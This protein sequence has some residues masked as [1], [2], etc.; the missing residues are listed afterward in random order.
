[1]LEKTIQEF[2]ENM[3]TLTNGAILNDAFVKIT[4]SAGNAVLISE[5]EWNMLT[6]AMKML[7]QGGQK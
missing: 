6:D 7:M 5:E 1:M 2:L 3:E 4:T